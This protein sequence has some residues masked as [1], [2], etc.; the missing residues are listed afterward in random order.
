MPLQTPLPRHAASVYV[1]HNVSGSRALVFRSQPWLGNVS[2]AA[3]RETHRPRARSV[4]RR[5]CRRR[6]AR[7]HAPTGSSVPPAPSLQMPAHFQ[8]AGTVPVGPPAPVCRLVLLAMHAPVVQVATA[9]RHLVLQERTAP[10]VPLRALVV[11]EA[12]LLPP[13]ASP[14][15]HYSVLLVRMRLLRILDAAVA[16]LHAVHCVSCPFRVF[17][18]VWSNGRNPL[19]QR[20]GVLSGGLQCADYRARWV[21]LCWWCQRHGAKPAEP[22]S[23]GLIL[24]ERAAGPLPRGHVSRHCWR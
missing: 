20:P 15:A 8:R 9:R 14:P 24:C 6:G 21:L 18:S 16:G 13:P 2:P 23:V 10:A 3:F 11:R 22:V 17:L 5:V 7:V 19:R 1:G 4:R 12:A